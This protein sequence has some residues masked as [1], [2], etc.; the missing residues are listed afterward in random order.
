MARV[1]LAQMQLSLPGFC[2]P[3]I[4]DHAHRRCTMLSRMSFL[5]MYE[6]NCEKLRVIMNVSFQPTHALRA[7]NKPPKRMYLQY[8]VHFVYLV[9]F[10]LIMFSS[11]LNLWT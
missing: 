8:F 5:D 11:T 3:R 2:W 10:I 9:C 7:T 6:A 1:F 4:E